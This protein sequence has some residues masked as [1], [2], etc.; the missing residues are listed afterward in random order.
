M[1]TKKRRCE[2][3]LKIIKTAVGAG[4]R[5][6]RRL[7]VP[8]QEGASSGLAR[9]VN[10]DIVLDL[11]RREQPIARVDLARLSGLQRSTISLIVEEL[12]REKWITE[13]VVVRTAR[14]RWPTLLTLNENLVIL[15]ADIHPEQAILSLM[16]LNG[17]FLTRELIP[18]GDNPGTALTALVERMQTMRESFP[19]RIFEGIGVSLPGRVVPE[20]Q[21]LI[22][23][24]N[25][26][27]N[28]YDVKAHL[29]DA[30][31]LQV[32][33]DN[34]ANAC[35]LSE[36]WF[37]RLPGVR[38]AVLITI[39]EGIG[40]AI[41][42]NGQLVLGTDG[43][44]GEFG[45]IPIDPAGPRCACGQDGCWEVFASSRATL[46]FYAN[47]KSK[48]SPATIQKLAL[49]AENGDSAAIAAIERQARFIAVGLR[50]VTAALSPEVILF[51]GDIHASWALSAPLIEA[52]LGKHMLAGT[53]PRLSAI[54]DGELARLR[55]AAALVLQRHAG[56]H[57]SSR[58]A[59]NGASVPKKTARRA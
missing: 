49:L 34:A 13:G 9:D 54:G 43:L 55:G 10:R 15:V 17:R 25:L 33:M 23:A 52:H 24:P 14:G 35:L 12:E 3:K 57:R 2:S 18:L 6:N 29:E 7:H 36:Q 30:M 38:N 11:L 51:A 39:S 21:H 4:V 41:L 22:L 44:A 42:A 48:K 37:G 27:W 26:R 56:Y 45:H 46:H 16:D 5:G 50:M 32:E 31:G 53:V 20:S 40:A 58:P 1:K 47:S 19:K 59:S 28:G 8:E